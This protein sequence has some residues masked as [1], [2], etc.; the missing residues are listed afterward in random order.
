MADASRAVR[1]RVRAGAGAKKAIPQPTSPGDVIE[2]AVT[3]E[4]TNKRGQKFWAK[5]GLSST[6]REGEST[7]Q[8]HD[9]IQSF[10]ITAVETLIEEWRDE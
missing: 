10:A 5:A 1:P 9:R 4:T 3:A 2:V 6:H 8:A 7:A